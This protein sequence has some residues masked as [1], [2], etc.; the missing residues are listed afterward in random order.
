MS[1]AF[2]GLLL[3]V[4]KCRVQTAKIWE[5]IPKETTSKE[6]VET[7]IYGKKHFYGQIP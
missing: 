7:R 6:T 2:V 1:D 5:Y 3:I 4:R